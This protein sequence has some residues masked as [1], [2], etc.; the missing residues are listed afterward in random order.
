MLN[1]PITIG[2]KIDFDCFEREGLVIG[3]SIN[4]MEWDFMAS[5][6]EPIYPKLVK[7]FYEN[8]EYHADEARIT[9]VVRN[10]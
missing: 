9:F 5:L 7:E 1:K 8:L 10:V 6:N 2:R 4:Y 3:Q